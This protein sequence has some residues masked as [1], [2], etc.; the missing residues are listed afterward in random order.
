MLPTLCKLLEVALERKEIEQAVQFFWA[1]ERCQE[2]VELSAWNSTNKSVLEQVMN[3]Q[4]N[5]ALIWL[6]DAC[7]GQSLQQLL[8]AVAMGEEMS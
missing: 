5:E 2:E 6:W 1:I 8:I 7:S 3:L 4:H